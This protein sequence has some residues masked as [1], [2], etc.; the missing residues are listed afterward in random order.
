MPKTRIVLP[1][2]APAGD[3]ARSFDALRAEYELSLD[4]PADALADAREAMAS[5][6]LPDRDETAVPF[7]TIDPVGSMDLDQAMYLEEADGGFRVRYA[8]ADVPLY[9][10][11]QGA[12]DTET[13]RRGQTIYMPDARIPLH[14]TELSEGAAS[15]LPNQVCSAFVWDMNLDAQGN[16]TEATLYRARVRSVERLDYTSVQSNVDSGNIDPRFALLKRIGELRAQLELE[17]GGASLPMPDQEVSEQSPGQYEV[18]FRPPVPSEDWNAQIS[19]MTGMVAAKMMLD[20][21]VGI[22]RTMPKPDPRDVERFRLQAKGLGLVWSAD[23]SYGA[24]LR[25]LDRNDPHHLALIHEAVTLFR[26]AAYTPFD[27]TPPEISEQAAVA[28]PYAH[29]TAPL[30]RLVDR[31]GL[32]ICEALANGQDVPAWAREA[33]PELPEIMK[34]SDSLAAK[35]DRACVDRVEAAVLSKFVG[36]TFG[37]FVVEADERDATSKV[38]V[39]LVDHA[40]VAPAR[41]AQGNQAPKPGEACTVR[42]TAADIMGGKLTFELVSEGAAAAVDSTAG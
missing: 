17:R 41:A 8:I 10:R 11:P 33:L 16:V 22:L 30:R 19:L 15:L 12:L 24:F 2:G 21:G 7:F 28:A 9:V 23:E 1:S 18:H 32:V 4:Y 31:F 14:P 20:G 29:V 26:G 42:L 36:Q 40:V 35:I 37:A 38:T 34:S 6:Q 25:R 39:Q 27:G 3:L 13:R 5:V